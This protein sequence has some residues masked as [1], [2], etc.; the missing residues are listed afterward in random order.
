MSFLSSC[1]PQIFS[2]D[3]YSTFQSERNKKWRNFNLTYG[4]SSGVGQMFYDYFYVFFITNYLVCYL[5]RYI[6]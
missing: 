3:I 1:N 2:L 4:T 5:R 6:D